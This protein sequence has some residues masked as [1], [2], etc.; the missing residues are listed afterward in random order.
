MTNAYKAIE[1]NKIEKSLRNSKEFNKALVRATK[2]DFDEDLTSATG[3]NLLKVTEVFN[4]R[5]IFSIEQGSTYF[6][7]YKEVYYIE[8]PGK[9]YF[10]TVE[11]TVYRRIAGQ[12]ETGDKK[13]AEAVAKEYGC[14]ITYRV[15]KA[16]KAE[17]KAEAKAAK[18]N[19]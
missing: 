15:S 14:D 19:A 16:T 4:I 1:E 6:K 8:N 12:H 13:W 7:L 18:E 3:M 2:G 10:D 11:P 17:A 9:Y 5:E